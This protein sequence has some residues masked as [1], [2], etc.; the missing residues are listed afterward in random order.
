[1]WKGFLATTLQFLNEMFWK[2]CGSFGIHS[3]RSDSNI[4]FEP[5]EINDHFAASV[6]CGD[7]F[8][9]SDIPSGNL[10]DGEFTFDDFG[11]FGI[12][13]AL[14]SISSSA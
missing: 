13:D 2:L 12:L 11:Q 7:V 8:D 6:N 9:N 3:K 5:N 1:M 14:E 10:G 4:D